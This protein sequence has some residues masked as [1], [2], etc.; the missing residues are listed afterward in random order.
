MPA[1]KRSSKE[2]H[3]KALKESLKDSRFSDMV[4]DIIAR[5]YLLGVE[6]GSS[7]RSSSGKLAREIRT[8][9]RMLMK[10]IDMQE[11][12]IHEVHEIRCKLNEVLDRLSG[13]AAVGWEASRWAPAVNSSV[14][15]DNPWAEVL[16]NK[17]I[18]S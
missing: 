11:K 8:L 10:Q 4:A 6:D 3:V 15:D 12:L 18:R 5:A 16:L 1:R 9:A 17:S 7:G 14:F 13:V 2:K